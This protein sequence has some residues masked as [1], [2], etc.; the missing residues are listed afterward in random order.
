MPNASWSRLRDDTPF[1]PPTQVDVL[2]RG[3]GVVVRGELDLCSAAQLRMAAAAAY[4]AE[5]G[6][7]D[8]A[9][10]VLDLAEVTFMDSAGLHVLNEIERQVASRAWALEVVAPAASG[11]RRLLRFAAEHGWV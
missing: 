11:P 1:E 3:R 7:G 9:S 5:P 2:E 8:A 6:D 10:F 4:R